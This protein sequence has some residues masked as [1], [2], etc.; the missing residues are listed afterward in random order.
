MHILNS[1]VI[2]VFL[3]YDNIDTVRSR[4]LHL[5]TQILSDIQNRTLDL[6]WV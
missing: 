2:H 5:S 4:T 1:G 3:N 6:T